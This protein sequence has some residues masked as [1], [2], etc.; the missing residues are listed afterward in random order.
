[1]MKGNGVRLVDYEEFWE[2]FFFLGNFRNERMQKWK[3]IKE[4]RKVNYMGLM[5]WSFITLRELQ[6]PPRVPIGPA[7]SLLLFFLK[8]KIKD[9]LRKSLGPK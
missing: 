1:M 7:I 5:P 3:M 4:L 8:K 6:T 2:D 9:G